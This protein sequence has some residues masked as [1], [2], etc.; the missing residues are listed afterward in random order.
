[1][2]QTLSHRGPDDSGIWLSESSQH[3][4]RAASPCNH[5]PVTHGTSTDGFGERAIYDYV[6][7]RNLQFSRTRGPNWRASE[8]GSVGIPIQKCLTGCAHW[9]IQST[10]ARLNGMFAIAVWD[11]EESAN[12]FYFVIGWAKSRSIGRFSMG[13]C[14]SDQ[15]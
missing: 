1:M 2:T 10:I 11:A 6:Q 3:C 12:F 8:L 7:R 14:Y 4:L 5:R 9:G 15:N 13:W